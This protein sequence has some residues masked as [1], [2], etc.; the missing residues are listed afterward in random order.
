MGQVLSEAPWNQIGGIE[1]RVFPTVVGITYLLTSEVSLSLWFFYL[2]T[3][4]QLI[5]AY[6]MGIMPSAIP[7]QF[8][9][10][11]W[12]KGFIGYQQF[13]AYFAYVGLCCGS[14]A[15]ISGTSCAALLDACRRV[16]ENEQKRFPI[17]SRSGDSLPLLR[18]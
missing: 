8:W 6:Y 9:T 2:F 12:A 5:M 1:V 3:K 16:K 10:R 4:A 13:G 11:G 17:R 15:S 7:D 18:L 14:V